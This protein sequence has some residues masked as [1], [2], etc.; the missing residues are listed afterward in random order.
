MKFIYKKMYRGSPEVFGK[1]AV[2]LGGDSAERNISLQSGT[3]IVEALRNKGVDVIAIDAQ[4]DW[5]KQLSDAAIERAFIALHG[6]GGEDG[7]V[8]AVLE[9]LNI[10]YTGSGHAASAIG[11]DKRLTKLIWRDMALPTPK[12]LTLKHNSQWSECL[13][14][15]GG[16][17]FIKPVHEGSSIGMNC[18]ATPEEMQRAFAEAAKYD[19]DVIAEQRIV[20]KEYTVVILGERVLPIIELLPKN[21]FYDFDAKYV[22]VETEY[23]CPASLPSA[24]QKQLETLALDA[25]HAVGCK[26]WGRVDV[27]LSNNG[28]FHLLEV[29][30]VPGMTNHSLVPIAAK[31]VGLDFDDLVLEILCQTLA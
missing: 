31:A 11:M 25:F 12:S 14:L 19:L 3:A 24:Q 30:T 28:E 20:G 16:E 8:Q 23:L 18:A 9:T 22:S 26:G 10:P 27:M 1:T 6:P 29:N 17:V 13:Q 5:V 2:L 21:S 4:T 15:L 7:K